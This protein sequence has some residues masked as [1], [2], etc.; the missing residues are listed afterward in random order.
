MNF[1]RW[2]I[3]NP[4]PAILIFIVLTILGIQSYNRLKVQ[5]FPDLDLPRIQIVVGLDGASP[6][7][8][9]TEITRKIEDA[10]AAVTLIDHITS[11]VKTGQS[12]TNV[13]FY[14]DKDSQ[15]AL[16]EIK[17][18][19]DSVRS[20]LPQAA[21]TPII[22]KDTIASS[23][24][25]SYIVKDKS[26]SEEELS[27]F[28]D[29][30]IS[31]AV[32][33]CN[34]I[35]N[36]TRIGGVTREI[37]V[38][39]NPLAIMKLGVTVSDI[40][41][42]LIATQK[43]FSAGS[44]TIDGL[45]QTI[46]AYGTSKTINDLKNIKVHL[47]GESWVR[48]GDVAEINDSIKDRTTLAFNK[49][50]KAIG[51]QITKAKDFSDITVY[52]E[53][54]KKIEDIKN[55]YKTVEIIESSNTIKPIK[56]NYQ[57]SIQLLYEG[58]ILA[59][60]VVFLFLRDIRAT[61]ISATALPLSIIPTFL[62]MDYFGLTLNIASLL[63]LALVVG[64]LV[65]DAIVEVENISQHLARGKKPLEAAVEAADEIGLA[66]IA[67]SLTL[68][69]V[70][71]P[72]AFMDGIPGMIFKQFGITAAASVLASLLVARLLTPMMAAYLMKG[73]TTKLRED[74]W[75]MKNYLKFV[76]LGIKHRF[77][78][79]CGVIIVLVLT[80]I[81]AKTI[82]MGFMRASDSGQTRISLSLQPGTTME[83]TESIAQKAISSVLN[84]PYVV[85]T[86]TTATKNSVS[87]TVDLAD[88]DKRP[89][90]NVIE[91]QLR[92]SLQDVPGVRANI[93]RG[94]NGES[95][96]ITL[97]SDN[98]ELVKD[99][100]RNLESDIRGIGRYG[101]ITSALSLESPEIQ[102]IPNF[103]LA[104]K[105][106]INT[107]T[108]ADAIK[109]STSGDYDSSLGKFN[110]PDRQVD[111]KVQLSPEYRNAEYIKSIQI[112]SSS[113]TIPLSSVA[114]V[115]YS[116]S[117]SDIKRIDRS[118]NIT[119][120]VE[121]NGV[122]VGKAMEEILSTKTMKNLPSNIKLINQGE[123]QRM[124]ELFESFGGAMLTGVLF[125][126]VVLVLLF[127]NFLQPITILTALP[128]SLCGAVAALIITGLSF[129][130]STLIALLMLMGI[131]TKNSILLVEYA[132]ELNKNNVGRTEALIDS[133]RK[134][135]RPIIMTTLAMGAG[136][137]P[138]ALGFGADPSFRQPM[139]IVVLG[140]LIA[141][142]VLSLFV[143][144]VFYTYVDDFSSTLMH[145]VKKK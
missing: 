14:L 32:L 92:K 22:T 29:N 90:Q 75:I 35:G 86:L 139:A 114:D 83:D 68:V 46:R 62:V 19:V 105:L 40:S 117:I 109:L 21:T 55:T 3:Y 93:G 11:T 80:V 18:T 38:N 130:M 28:I 113:G 8:I 135:S 71:L 110:L 60:I 26:K 6:Q 76:S 42:Q 39:L 115:R 33:E 23:V 129:T 37:Q 84:N 64:I 17:S 67:T 12:I 111:I 121:L 70:F 102:I 13:S 112:K 144:P 65:D 50:E 34:G 140:G 78:S 69:A 125:I 72:T 94:G 1:S 108:L 104:S 119:I 85:N 101:N 56:E 25:V 96:D 98:I 138:I 126:Y 133:C 142:T 82:D 120:N 66:V 73:H 103:D 79:L 27:W 36:I 47:N 136:M 51:F 44:T 141:S 106:G 127:H 89:K 31:K 59:V 48:L 100:V 99:V 52:D 134:R 132:M 63:A 137:M 41:A 20:D 57:G 74:S 54:S 4:V 118:R 107:K 122:P 87:M 15:V 16:D 97:A 88:R 81:G 43:D 7:Q 143:V 123:A 131:V 95:L 49:Q 116:G 77:I 10:V 2:A 24:L 53:V 128:L 5:N 61:L 145:F 124:N 91:A 9:E 58:A 30:D 45:D